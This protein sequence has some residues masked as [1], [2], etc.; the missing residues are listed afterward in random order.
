MGVSCY[1]GHAA[2]E[3]APRGGKSDTGR[4]GEREG[5]DCVVEFDGGRGDSGAVDLEEEL[6]EGETEIS[7]CR[8]PRD[9]Y[10]GRRDRCVKGV[11]WWIQKGEIGD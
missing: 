8:V 4:E 2:G 3:I 5:D 7:A 6:N 9:D 1:G 11:W 10:L